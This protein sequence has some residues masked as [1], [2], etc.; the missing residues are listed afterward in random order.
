M[1]HLDQ[2]NGYEIPSQPKNVLAILETE[3]SGSWLLFSPVILLRTSF[4]RAAQESL[5]FLDLFDLKINDNAQATNTMA[6]SPIPDRIII[7]KIPTPIFISSFK[8]FQFLMLLCFS[9]ESRLRNQ[10][11][12]SLIFRIRS[13]LSKPAI[14]PQY[15][16]LSPD[17]RTL[18]P[19]KALHWRVS[20]CS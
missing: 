14:R 6:T 3:A 19:M 7:S 4:Q 18:L 20:L 17:A 16:H 10:T 8:R 12:D 5:S 2:I 15:F 11:L 1:A 9:E 13:L